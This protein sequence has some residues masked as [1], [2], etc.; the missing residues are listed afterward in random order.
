[1]LVSRA[2]RRLTPS[3]VLVIRLT[4]VVVRE[5]GGGGG[6]GGVAAARSAGV[7]LGGAASSADNGRWTLPPPMAPVSGGRQRREWVAG[8]DR[9]CASVRPAMLLH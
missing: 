5:G 9:A 7:A 8:S 1:M 2:H 4:Q 3:G 6:G